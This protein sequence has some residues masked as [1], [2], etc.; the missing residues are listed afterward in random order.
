MA[1]D[2]VN[3]S[4][5]TDRFSSSA[6]TRIRRNRLDVSSMVIINLNECLWI[7][8]ICR[9]FGKLASATK[10]PKPRNKCIDWD[11]CGHA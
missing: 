2:K 8:N 1:M 5:R 9:L 7:G 6:L 4:L 11:K 3:R 10:K